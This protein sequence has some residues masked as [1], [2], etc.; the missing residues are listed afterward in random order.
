[1]VRTQDVVQFAAPIRLDYP[2]DLLP[3]AVVAVVLVALATAL[4]LVSYRRRDAD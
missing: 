4:V 3:A 2:L 1:M